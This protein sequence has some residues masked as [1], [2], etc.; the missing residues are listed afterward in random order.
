MSVLLDSSIIL[1]KDVF[2]FCK[3]LFY[4]YEFI[5]NFFNIVVYDFS[6]TFN[7]FILDMMPGVEKFKVENA[8]TRVS[9]QLR[10]KYL[11][12]SV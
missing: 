4:Y 6:T 5:F 2:C 12:C 9:K 8:S 1:F 7:I 3:L 11:N 10:I